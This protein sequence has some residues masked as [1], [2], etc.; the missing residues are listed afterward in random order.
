MTRSTDGVTQRVQVANAHHL[1]IVT[2][3]RPPRAIA[4]PLIGTHDRRQIAFA[5]GW[6]WQGACGN[7]EKAS[8]G[9]ST[10]FL[11][12]EGTAASRWS[13]DER[14]GRRARHSPRNPEP[15]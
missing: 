4:E 8:T 12:T 10:P 13:I 5:Q 1:V 15:S 9:K 3:S 14:P 2:P 7:E 11:W 6:G